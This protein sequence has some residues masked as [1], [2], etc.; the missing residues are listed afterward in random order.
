MAS[1]KQLL[2]VFNES[3]QVVRH[4][5]ATYRKTGGEMKLSE[6]DETNSAGTFIMGDAQAVMSVIG[7]VSDMGHDGLRE[8]RCMND[9]ISKPKRG[10]P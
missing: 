2:A 4:A 5:V 6:V 3:G 8:V 7:H 9:R 1:H 10:K